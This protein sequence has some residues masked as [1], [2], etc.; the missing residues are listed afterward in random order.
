MPPADYLTLGL[1][2]FAVLIAT[3]SLMVQFGKT[4]IIEVNFKRTAK[5]RC[6]KG[7]KLEEN[8]RPLLKALIKIKAENREFNLEQIYNINKPMFKKEKLLERLYE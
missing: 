6:D 4:T 5:L 1:T 2:F 3:L 8:E 7:K